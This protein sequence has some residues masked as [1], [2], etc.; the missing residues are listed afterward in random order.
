MGGGGMWP[1]CLH[2]TY[3]MGHKYLKTIV[4]HDRLCLI[5]LPLANPPVISLE[6][7]CILLRH[8]QP[9]CQISSC[10]PGLFSYY[11]Y[12]GLC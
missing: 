8:E 1:I 5:N 11:M 6:T 7:S 2:R 9:L 10:N 3:D 12:D 4:D